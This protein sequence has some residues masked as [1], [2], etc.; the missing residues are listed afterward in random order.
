M[1]TAGE[2]ERPSDASGDVEHVG[3]ALVRPRS[4]HRADQLLEHRRHRAVRLDEREDH[5]RVDGHLGLVTLDAVAC[6]ELLVVRDD[7]VVDA[8][9]G[10]VADGVVV[11]GDRRVA[12]RV[13]ADVDEHLPGSGGHDDGVE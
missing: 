5:L 6:E 8:R 13:V 11:R 2:P 4:G 7:P 1:A 12:L 9:H 10:A 3:L